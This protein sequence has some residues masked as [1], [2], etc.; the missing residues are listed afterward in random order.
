[1]NKYLVMFVSLSLCGAALTGCSPG[2]NESGATIFG[3]AAGG[4]VANKLFGKG[5][6]KVLAT[7]AGAALGGYIGNQYGKYMDRQDRANMQRAITTTPVG[8]QATWTNQ[9]TQ[10]GPVTYNVRPVRN[11]HSAGRYC[12]EYQTAITVGGRVKKAYGKACRQPDG[13]WKIVK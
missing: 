9:N 10:S 6:G 12:R 1:M 8:Q 4:L 3:A 2:N 7:M 13:Q 5:D 11:F